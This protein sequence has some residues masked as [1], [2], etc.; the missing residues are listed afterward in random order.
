MA[1]YEL[2]RL[3]H[4]AEDHEPGDQVQSSV[5]AKSTRRRHDGLHTWERQTEDTSERVVDADSPG[6]TLLAVDC[7]EH[8]CRILE[9]D[10]SF[11][12]RVHDGEEVDEQ[13]HRADLRASTARIVQKGKTSGKQEDTHQWKCNEA[14]CSAAF[15]VDEEQ[16]GD[17]ENNLNRTIAEGGVESLFSGVADSLEDGGR[18]ERDDVNYALS[19]SKTSEWDI[20]AYFRTSA[21]QA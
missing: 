15:G 1:T 10:W 5:E 7:G 12:E 9:G 16:R 4:E 3:A 11:A 6:H 17:C 20:V 14:Q 21:G 8:L 13:H 18:V 19:V 2:L